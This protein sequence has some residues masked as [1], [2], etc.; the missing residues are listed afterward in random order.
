MAASQQ[1]SQRQANF[2][3]LAE[4]DFAGFGQQLESPL[5]S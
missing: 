2:P 3:I 4:N 1:T 5:V